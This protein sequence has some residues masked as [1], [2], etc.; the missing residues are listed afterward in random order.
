MGRH[1]TDFGSHAAKLIIEVDGDT[2][3]V[4]VAEDGERDGFI[5]GEG[6]RIVRLTNREVM[7]NIEGVGLLLMQALAASPHPTPAGPPSPRGGGRK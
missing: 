5:R 4:T 1:F 7:N 3:A 2:H 6:Y